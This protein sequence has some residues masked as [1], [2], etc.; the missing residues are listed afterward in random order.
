MIG[1]TS[2]Y[3]WSRLQSVVYAPEVVPREVNGDHRSMVLNLLTVA[4]R[5]PS[6]SPHRHTHGQIRTLNVRRAYVIHVWVATHAVGFASDAGSGAVAPLAF[7]VDLAVDLNQ[8]RVINVVAERALDGV[9]VEFQA[10]GRQ[11]DAIRKTTSQVL[12]ERTR[13]GGIPHPDHPRRNQLRVRVDSNPRP[14]VSA[15][16]V[17]LNL[18]HRDVL[19]FAADKRPDFVSLNPLAGEITHSAV[20]EADAALAEFHQELRNGVLRNAGHADGRADRVPLDQASDDLCTA[21]GIKAVHAD[22]YA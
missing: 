16:P 9:Q 2:R 21:V 1:N 7:R 12:D 19:L 6:E 4:V 10:I 11:L 20:H 18:L 13:R 5:R 3:G 14:N 15:Y 22:Y 8:H 17:P